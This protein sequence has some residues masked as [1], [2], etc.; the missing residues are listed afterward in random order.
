MSFLYDPPLLL[1]AGAILE[2][3]PVDDDTRSTL[4]T[5]IA[6]TFIT[7]SSAL[8]LDVPGLDWFWRPFGATSG[9]DFMITSGLGRRRMTS[10]GRNGHL[11]A[12][13]A[14][15]TYPLWLAAGRR[16]GQRHQHRDQSPTR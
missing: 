15:A 4:G 9:R 13:F 14:L 16:L 5:G 1:A 12:A 7:G 8:W 11:L 2:Q 6:A 10:V 3:L